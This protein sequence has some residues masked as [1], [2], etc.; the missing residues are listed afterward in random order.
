MIHLLGSVPR[1]ITVAVSGGVDSMVLY[2]F[3]SRNHEVSAVFVDHGTENS[4]RAYEF[5]V[6]T[7]VGQYG[8]SLGIYRINQNRPKDQSWE[9]HWRNE[10][11]RY[12]RTL[13]YVATAHNLDDVA[14]TWIW[15]SLNGTTSL[16]PYRHDNV[17][18]PFLATRK[19]QLIDWAQRKNVPWIEDTSNQ[20]TAY[21]RNYIRHE[22]MPHAL[23]VNPGLHSMLARRLQDRQDQEKSQLTDKT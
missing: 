18:R 6:D 22:L 11:Y 5:L 7:I 9:E 16:M 17:I 14:E 1:T 15:S 8:R 4:A 19:S 20:D 23:R 2:D 21:T 3:L 10:R 13:G 12:F